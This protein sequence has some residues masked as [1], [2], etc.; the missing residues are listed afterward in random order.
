MKEEIFYVLLEEHLLERMKTFKLDDWKYN[1]V[2]DFSGEIYIDYLNREFSIS[3]KFITENLYNETEVYH[4]IQHV[5]FNIVETKYFS[6]YA[7]EISLY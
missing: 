5:L 7:K 6:E 1:F 2:D 3:K 4:K